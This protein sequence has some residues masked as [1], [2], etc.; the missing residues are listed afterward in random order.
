MYYTFSESKR[1]IFSWSS[2]KA[3]SKQ[4]NDNMK[5]TNKMQATLTK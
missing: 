1:L 3:G 2:I 4:P 5:Q